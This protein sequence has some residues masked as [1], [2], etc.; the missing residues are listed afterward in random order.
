MRL[1]ALSACSALALTLASAAA[2]AFSDAPATDGPGVQ[3]QFDDP[4]EAVENLA[5]GAAG[6]S[7]TELS[8][9]AQIPS[10]GPLAQRVPAEP[11]NAEPVNPNW[12]AWMIWHQ[13]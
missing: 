12:P 9:G 7:G 1:L 13:Q 4:D 3:N 6:G 8:N 11:E 2:F 10:G 5:N